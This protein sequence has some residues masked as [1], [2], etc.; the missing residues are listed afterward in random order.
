MEMNNRGIVFTLMAIVI[1]S[2][3]MV[4]LHTLSAVSIAGAQPELLRVKVIDGITDS[5]FSYSTV[6]LRASTYAALTN[7]S[8]ILAEQSDPEMNLYFDDF[9]DFELNLQNCMLNDTSDIESVTGISSAGPCMNVSYYP[10]LLDNYIDLINDSFNVD[11]VYVINK[12][13]FNISQEIPFEITIKLAMDVNITDDFA[14]W[15]IYG[16]NIFVRVPLTGVLDPVMAK[17]DA[18][19]TYTVASGNN[20]FVAYTIKENKESI[21]NWSRFN[22]T[23]FLNIIKNKEYRKALNRSP[24]FLQRY[25]GEFSVPSECCG[26][27]SFINGSHLNSEPWDKY[28]NTLTQNYSFTDHELFGNTDSSNFKPKSYVSCNGAQSEKVNAL[29]PSSGPNTKSYF[30]LNYSTLDYYGFRP[31]NITDC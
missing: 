15:T 9:D 4:S 24:S 6:A 30:W 12:T 11:I 29:G 18:N 22:T 27:E 25:Y 20:E 13:S 5:F 31:P 1:S 28:E 23:N 16:Q 7:M 14:K 26:I 8:I 2:V 21:G 3:I 19:D 10:R 17:F